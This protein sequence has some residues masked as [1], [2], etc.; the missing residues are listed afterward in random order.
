MQMVAR[1][2]ETHVQPTRT[3]VQ[4]THAKLMIVVVTPTA[5]LAPAVPC[6]PLLKNFSLAQE[7]VRAL[8]R[9]KA[10]HHESRQ[11]WDA[12]ARRNAPTWLKFCSIDLEMYG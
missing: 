5:M 4:E 2:V 10:S 9:D 3:V 6:L 1:L 11:I 7:E 8:S 12:V